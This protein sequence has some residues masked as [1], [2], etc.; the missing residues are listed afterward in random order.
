MISTSTAL[1]IDLHRPDII[2]R[3]WGEAES[4]LPRLSGPGSAV[5]GDVLVYMGADTRVVDIPTAEAV[6]RVT[7]TVDQSSADIGSDIPWCNV[8][9]SDWKQVLRHKR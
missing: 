1:D 2:P 6:A 5:D 4:T 3:G 9:H 8:G 7:S